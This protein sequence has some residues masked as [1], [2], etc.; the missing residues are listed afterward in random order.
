M[1][2]P[3][4]STNTAHLDLVACGG[5]RRVA[6]VGGPRAIDRR[7]SAKPASGPSSRNLGAG[8]R[9]RSRSCRSASRTRVLVRGCAVGVSVA[10]YYD[11]T[12]AQF[13]TRDPLE[14]IT[15]APYGYASSDP[16]DEIDPTGLDSCG[17]F[18]VVCNTLVN[19]GRGATGGLTDKI[20]NWISPGSSCTVAQNSAVADIAFA[21][22]WL[23]GEGE[24]AAAARAAVRFTDDQQALVKLAQL[25]KRSGV[26]ADDAETLLKWAD[27]V[28]L[29][30][31]GPEIH[32]NRPVV[33]SWHIHV[34]PVDHIPVVF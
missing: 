17:I 29:P 30:A 22:S 32:P 8:C 12:T 34:G 3:L 4:A 18:S 2:R 19:I 33:N 28:G 1:S 27:E 20:D 9:P 31:R 21:G 15:R 23:D 16:L 24:A 26:S 13:L 25:A 6:V 10:R 11:P 7:C 5:R 14:S